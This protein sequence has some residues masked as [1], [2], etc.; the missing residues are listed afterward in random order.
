MYLFVSERSL[1]LLY[2]LIESELVKVFRR[3]ISQDSR[4]EKNTKDVTVTRRYYRAKEDKE[5]EH[6][7][8]ISRSA[9]PRERKLFFLPDKVVHFR[10]TNRLWADSAWEGYDL[11]GF[12]YKQLEPKLDERE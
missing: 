4:Q 2:E 1:L 3:A 6:D 10:S 11:D 12:S 5:Q 9:K 7:E 8:S